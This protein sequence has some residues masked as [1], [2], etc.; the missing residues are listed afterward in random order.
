M[1]LPIAC[2]DCGATYL[3]TDRL[4]QCPTC[5][6]KRNR[7]RAAERRRH[8][9][10]DP[11]AARGYGYQWRKLSLRARRAQPFCSDCGT[12]DDLTADHSPE[13]W[14]RHESG[15]SVRLVDIDVVCRR[16]NAERGAARGPGARARNRPTVPTP[17]EVGLTDDEITP[18]AQG[19]VWISREKCSTDSLEI[20]QQW[21]KP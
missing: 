7:G 12:E 1:Q 11:Q 8:Y 14:I 10:L 3:R 15:K 9:E 19:K 4:G 18:P 20:D 21:P 5:R 17:G 16:C 13:A 2:A 6:P